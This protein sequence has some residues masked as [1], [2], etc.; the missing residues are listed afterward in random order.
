MESTDNFKTF[1]AALAKG[2][3]DTRAIE[4]IGII[5][6]NWCRKNKLEIQWIAF[7]NMVWNDTE[8]YRNIHSAAMKIIRRENTKTYNNYKALIVSTAE[9]MLKK[10]F[11]NFNTL[12]IEKNNLAWKRVEKQLKVYAFKWHS[13]RTY[14]KDSD[15]HDLHWSAIHILFEKLSFKKL[16]FK[17]SFELKS[18]Y[19][20]ILENKMK[21]HFREKKKEN[22][23]S[24]E[25][26]E[27][28]YDT[29]DSKEDDLICFVKKEINKLAENE[30][31]IIQEYFIYEKKLTEI[32]EELNI[33]A[34]NCRVIKHR[35][36]KKLME[37]IP[38]R[39]KLYT[40][41]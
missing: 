37:S 3:S 36:L 14:G 22:R 26:P 12:L 31:Y 34:E 19:F 23:I 30:K 39:E 8:F 6:R 9:K 10:G 1:I 41:S 25:I 15:C 27:L 4:F 28:F 29:D 16:H 33:S 17:N 24:R 11:E 18:Y 38:E 21:E 35:A 5:V 32:A 7:E 20:R 2:E 40:L 13:S